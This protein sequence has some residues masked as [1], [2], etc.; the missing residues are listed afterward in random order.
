LSLI[1]PQ[2]VQQAKRK[3]KAISPLWAQLDTTAIIARRNRSAGVLACGLERRPA[4]RTKPQ[5]SVLAAGRCG[6]SPPGR[7]RY[8]GGVKL[9]PTAFLDAVAAQS[10]SGAIF[11]NGIV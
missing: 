5:L 1:L 4:A 8:G 6:N 11:G 10:D 3:K 7:L 9:R 2:I